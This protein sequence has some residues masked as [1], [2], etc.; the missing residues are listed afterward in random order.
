MNKSAM[1]LALALLS[2]AAQG[3]HKGSAR[4]AQS[5]ALPIAPAPQRSSALVPYQPAGWRMAPFEELER[6]T[7]WIG[8]IVIRHQQS[9]ASLFRGGDWRPDDPNP[10]RSPA[11]AQALAEKIAAEAAAAPEQFEQLARLHSD[12]ALSRNDGGMLGGVRAS[13]LV[14]TDFLDPLAVLKVGEISR[15]F[16]TPFGVHI[17]KR[18]PP[19]PEEQVAGERIVIAYRGVFGGATN[20]QRSHLEAQALAS[21]IAAEARKSPQTFKALVERYSENADRSRQGDMGVYSTRDPG[22]W[23][24]EILHLAQLEVGQV[25]GPLDSPVGFQ[26]LKRVPVIPHTEYAMTSIKVPLGQGLGNAQMGDNPGG[27]EVAQQQA[28]ETAEALRLALVADPGR[29]K[30]FQDKY[31]CDRIQ[32]WTDGRGD[33]ELTRFVDALS[34]GQIAKEPVFYGGDLLLVKRLDPRQLP[35]EK[36]RLS[37][38]PNPSEP[39][40]EALL[41]YNADGRK[42]A[43]ASRELVEKVKESKAFSAETTRTIAKAL[44]NLAAET[45]HADDHAAVGAAVRATLVAL[46]RDLGAERY[47]AFKDFG[48]AWIRAHLM[49]SL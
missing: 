3:C 46:E 47:N 1:A 37:E 41:K 6:T 40:Y 38:V 34:L 7:L 22:D 23:P 39:N 2:Y 31:C 33:L 17:L 35:P 27:P 21:K 28:L 48:R 24:A 45:E 25:T 11:E 18:Y 42:V 43:P 13:H 10:P 8:H 16:V 26:I 44:G 5:R 29:F 32:R 12:D 49:P 20:T 9:D 36:P 15:P 19:P 30:E 14:A 4:A